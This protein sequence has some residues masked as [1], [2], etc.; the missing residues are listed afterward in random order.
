[1]RE[2][3]I[4]NTKEIVTDILQKQPKA[5]DN[6][7]LLICLVYSRLGHH[8]TE[9]FGNIMACVSEG[10]LPSFETIT[11]VRR[12]VQEEN[13]EL[14]GETR[15]LRKELEEEYKQLAKGEI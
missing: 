4:K 10:D 5:R 11:R 13:P 8:W 14:L 7:A 9:T 15:F 12:K 3:Q 2:Q 6:D 1:M